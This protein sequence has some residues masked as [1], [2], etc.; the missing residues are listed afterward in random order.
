MNEATY[1]AIP[2]TSDTSYWETKSEQGITRFIPRD[3]D[4]HHQLK[5]KAWATI[6][7]SLPQKNR[8]SAY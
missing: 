5:L 4:L 8:K 7:A 6:Q 2:D 3:K 1:T